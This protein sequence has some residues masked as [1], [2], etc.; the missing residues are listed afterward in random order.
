MKTQ[1]K[2]E[3]ITAPGVTPAG[4]FLSYGKAFLSAGTPGRQP[5][6]CIYLNKEQHA[7]LKRITQVIGHDAIPLS[8]YLSNIVAHHLRMFDEAIS[9][10]FEESYKALL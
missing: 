4:T 5:I 9:K 2:D 6:K 7:R 10:E 3:E 1:N 8:A